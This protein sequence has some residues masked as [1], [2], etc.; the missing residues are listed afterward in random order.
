MSAAVVSIVFNL[1]EEGALVTPHI[2]EHVSDK[3]A[4]DGDK[5]NEMTLTGFASL[6]ALVHLMVLGHVALQVTGEVDGGIAC[7]GRALLG[8]MFGLEKGVAR[9]ILARVEAHEAGQEGSRRETLD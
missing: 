9:D 8:D 5:R 6:D 2:V 1:Q 3:V 7:V 4:S